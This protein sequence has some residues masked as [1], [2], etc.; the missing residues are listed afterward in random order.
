MHVEQVGQHGYVGSSSLDRGMYWR[1]VAFIGQDEL[2]SL[3]TAIWVLGTEMSLALFL[4]LHQSGFAFS[5]LCKDNLAM[6]RTIMLIYVILSL[7]EC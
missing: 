4:F 2:E 7:F 6:P 5:M 3:L 1:F